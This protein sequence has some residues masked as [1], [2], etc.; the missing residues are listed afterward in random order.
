MTDHSIDDNRVSADQ[1]KRPRPK[2]ERLALS[3]DETAEALSISRRKVQQLVTRRE[4]PFAR[5]DRRLV[6]PVDQLRE[7][8]REQASGE[9][10]T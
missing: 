4:I 10:Q 5:V 6:F 3:L 7:W 1:L 2:V 8:L 9:G